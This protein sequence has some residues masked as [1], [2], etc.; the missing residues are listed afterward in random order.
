MRTEYSITSLCEYLEV[1]RSGYSAW[2]KRGKP[3]FIRFDIML[4]HI[5]KYLFDIKPHGHRMI[6][7]LIRLN[8]GLVYD[9]KTILRYMNILGL[10][11]PVRM[12]KTEGT[13]NQDPNKRPS[14]VL[15]NALDRMFWADRPLQVL[16]TD[17]THV[18]HKNGQ[19]CL[20]VL[21]DLYDNSIVAYQL[22]RFNDLKLVMDTINEFLD[23]Y[24]ELVS[25]PCVI[26][27]DRGS[28]Y[29]SKE[30]RNTLNEN[31]IIISHSR[32]GNPLDNSPCENWFGHL[33][34]EAL[35]LY[36]PEDDL[37]LYYCI[38]EY[39]DYYNYR[40]PQRKLKGMTPIQFRNHSL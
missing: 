21:K 20:S 19:L 25:F 7:D 18:Y 31:L 35:K 28:Q 39:I 11:S 30:Y 22:S 37:D 4:A 38:E 12:N 36:L 16:V 29:T 1:S 33:K 27:S 17:V 10:K 13:T 3:K 34:S 2:V 8:Y 6:N 5:V 15:P 9:D 26:H 23:K 14:D 24:S 40:R 32:Q